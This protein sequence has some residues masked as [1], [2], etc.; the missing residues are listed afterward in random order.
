MKHFSTVSKAPA[1]AQTGLCDNFESEMQVKLC[2]LMQILTSVLLPV[3]QDK[4]GDQT[5]T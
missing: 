2:F 5:T 1:K 3:Y 4:N